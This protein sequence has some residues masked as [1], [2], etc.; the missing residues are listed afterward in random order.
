MK[1]F[2]KIFLLAYCF[3]FLLKSSQLVFSKRFVFLS[4][5]FRLLDSNFFKKKEGTLDKEI[6]GSNHS[7]GHFY[8]EL[9]QTLAVFSKDQS[10]A[11]CTTKHVEIWN[12]TDGSLIKTLQVGELELF[13]VLQAESLVVTGFGDSIKIWNSTN[14]EL[15]KHLKG[16][17]DSITYFVDLSQDKLGLILFIYLAF[18]CLF[19]LTYV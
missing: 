11:S 9:S 6:R 1:K 12:S 10:I 18:Y 2:E 7:D 19:L 13:I 8:P 16:H 5:I 3:T 15:I 14:G 17:S 4:I